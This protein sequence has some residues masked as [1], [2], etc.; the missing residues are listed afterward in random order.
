MVST[1]GPIG[2]KPGMFLAVQNR[3]PE[4]TSRCWISRA[5]TSLVSVKPE[6]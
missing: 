5:L 3:L 1:K 6:M 2:P 4:A